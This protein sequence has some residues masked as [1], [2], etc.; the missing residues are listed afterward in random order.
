MRNF[1]SFGGLSG[2]GW[3]LDMSLLL[4]QV[5]VLSV[6]EFAANMVSSLVAAGTVFLLSR[7]FIFASAPGKLPLRMASYLLYT[8]LVVLIASIALHWLADFISRLAQQHMMELGATTVAAA[9]KILITPPQ[10][11]LNFVMSRFM[12]EQP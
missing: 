8:V 7:R 6:P 12:N 9:A 4:I 3:L 11:L 10:L 2:L 5:A 1:L